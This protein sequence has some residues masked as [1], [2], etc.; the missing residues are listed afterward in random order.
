MYRRLLWLT[1]AVLC[2]A[3]AWA[4]SSPAARQIASR[5]TANSLKAD[6]SFLAS[7]ALQG[8]ATPSPGLDIA[9]EYIAAQFRRA[10]LEPAG[11]DGYFQTAALQSATPNPDGVE[12]TLEAGE[13]TVKA[14]KAAAQS[15]KVRNVA[16]LLRGSDPALKDTYVLITGHYD[17]L[18]VRG[19]GAGDHIYNGA[20][21]DAS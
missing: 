12:L 15:V 17:H 19:E 4:Q 14:D 8:R 5:L 10:G 6:V 9:A 21:D 1:A 16:G 7:D 11:D 2:A 13:A 20:N 3:S 18:G